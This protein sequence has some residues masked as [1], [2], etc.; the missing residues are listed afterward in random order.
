MFWL[1]GGL[2]VAILILG[3][4]TGLILGTSWLNLR[5]IVPVAG[6]FG[7]SLYGLVLF[8]SAHR[9]VL[10]NFLDRYTFTGSLLMALLLIYLGL[11]QEPGQAGAGAGK[12]RCAPKKKVCSGFG[13]WKYV[14]GFLPCPLCLVALAFSVILVSSM[15]GSTS[16]PQLGRNVAVLFSLII[17]IVAVA[18]RKL[19]HYIKFNPTAVFNN[20][21][22]FTGL[23]TLIFA[24]VVPN[25]VQAMAMPLTPLI[26][27][28]PHWVII[29]WA[30]ISCLSL[31]GY[32][33]YLYL[34]D[35]DLK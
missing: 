6:I 21:L 35:R 18:I 31:I 30:G 24:L 15:V 33:K 19:I 9:Q 22:L 26:I 29:L 25:F 13:Y 32:F 16:L 34:K 20:L 8:F 5:W 27:S 10:I 7:V 4:K 2:L 1:Q 12:T 11:Q 28:S 14:L 23:L 17:V 3:I